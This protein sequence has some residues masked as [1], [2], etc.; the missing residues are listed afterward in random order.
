MGEGAKGFRCECARCSVSEPEHGVFDDA[1]N[2]QC[3]HCR[4]GSV[5]WNGRSSR[6]FTACAGSESA[7]GRF[8]TLSDQV[9]FNFMERKLS[10]FLMENSNSGDFE[11]NALKMN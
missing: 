7:C 2:L 1:R 3:Q 8:P 9:M 10:V 11:V 4:V 5:S 6:L